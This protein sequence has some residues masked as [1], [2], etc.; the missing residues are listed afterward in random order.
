MHSFLF[1]NEKQASSKQ[2]VILFV[3]ILVWFYF[4]FC[5][6]YAVSSFGGHCGFPRGNQKLCTTSRWVSKEPLNQL[7]NVK[8]LSKL[9]WQIF[10]LPIYFA[11]AKFSFTQCGFHIKYVWVPNFSF[12]STISNIIQNNFYWNNKLARSDINN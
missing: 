1:Y 5:R 12:V 6:I 10:C 8:L 4:Y 7:C 3:E 11:S 2:K 9:V